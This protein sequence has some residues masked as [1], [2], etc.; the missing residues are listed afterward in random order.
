MSV[1]VRTARADDA[2]AAA[3][4]RVISWQSAYRG[5]VPDAYLDAM[6]PQKN[7]D[8]WRNVAAGGEPGTELLVAEESGRIVGFAV[9][10]TAR[11]PTFGYGGE[12]HAIY[13]LPEAMGKG[14]GTLMMQHIIAGLRRLGHDDMIVWVMEANTRGRK[15]YE[16]FAGMT[17]VEN[18][19]RSFDIAGTTLWEVAYGLRPLALLR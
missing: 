16:H 18:S 19:R 13:W 4:V 10:G 15:F 3:T 7:L 6:S 11:P 5:V 9:Y 2:L 12:L 1:L 8:H 14:Y 17:E